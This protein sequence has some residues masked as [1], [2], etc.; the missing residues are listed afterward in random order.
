LPANQCAKNNAKLDLPVPK[1]PVILHAR[2][3]EFLFKPVEIRVKH[4]KANVVKM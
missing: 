3:L 4:S 1:S 2:W